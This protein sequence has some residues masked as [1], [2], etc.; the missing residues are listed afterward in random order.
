MARIICIGNKKGGIGKSSTTI[1]LAGC[2]AVDL[3]QRVLILDSD[4]QQTVNDLRQVEVES[5]IEN[6]P[7]DISTIS[8]NELS[9]F[10]E[11]N[12]DKYDIIFLDMPRMTGND[13]DNIVATLVNCDSM[14]IPFVAS[15]P[16][17]MSTADF[18]NTIKILGDIRKEE[19]LPFY[20][21][22]FLNRKSSLKENEYIPEFAQ[23]IGVEIFDTAIKE[24]K[25]FKNLSTS[26]SLLSTK[27]GK[28]E[29]GPFL[30][31]FITKFELDISIP[32][33]LLEFNT[34]QEVN[35][36]ENE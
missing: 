18:M 24:K 30:R 27:E 13:D 5:G 28:K 36:L 23:Q 34:T 20:V 7:Y 4:G 17:T 14:L 22:G 1:W 32:E 15:A 29:F 9:E 31:E 10:I 8:P 35:T 25:I 11:Q 3:K 19:D 6:F 2:L 26:T 12:Y 16:D 21:Y 33:D